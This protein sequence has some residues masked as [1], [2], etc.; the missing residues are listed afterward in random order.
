[1]AKRIFILTRDICS[2]MGCSLR[3]AQRL[4]QEMQFVF[5]KEKYQKLTIKEFAKH[6]GIAPAEIV[7][8]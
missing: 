6:M 8:Y 7:L 4:V 5:G 1:M 2:L 3:K